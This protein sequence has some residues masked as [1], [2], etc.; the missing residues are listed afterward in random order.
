MI[1]IPYKGHKITITQKGTL[2]TTKVESVTV[3][4]AEVAADVAI[5]KAKQFI[6]QTFGDEADPSQ[7]TGGVDASV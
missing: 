4:T 3:F 7:F 1:N 6:D 5:A 2:V